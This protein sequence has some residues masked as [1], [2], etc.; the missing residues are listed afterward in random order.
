M[1]ETAFFVITGILLSLGIFFAL[2]CIASCMVSSQISREEER[3]Q[4][5]TCYTENLKK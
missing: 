3:N 5:E 4:E 1:S 2:C